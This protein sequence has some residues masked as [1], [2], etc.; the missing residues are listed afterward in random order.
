MLKRTKLRNLPWFQGERPVDVRVDNPSVF[1]LY[2]LSWKCKLATVTSYK[3]DVS[4]VSPS[5]EWFHKGESETVLE[6]ERLRIEILTFSPNLLVKPPKSLIIGE[7]VYGWLGWNELLN[8]CSTVLAL[9]VC[10]IVFNSVILLGNLIRIQ[11]VHRFQYRLNI[12]LRRTRSHSVLKYCAIFWP[13]SNHPGNVNVGTQTNGVH[14]T[15]ENEWRFVYS[16]ASLARKT[17][18]KL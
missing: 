5:S 17:A 4:S 7:N 9:I 1:W 13:A 6:T 11:Q 14:S 12:F 16:V 10:N 15:V 8:C 18:F 2:Q 3:A